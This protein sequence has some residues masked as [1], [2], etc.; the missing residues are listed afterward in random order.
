MVDDTIYLM[1]DQ[2]IVL[3]V[4]GVLGAGL[5][6]GGIGLIFQGQFQAGAVSIIVGGLIGLWLYRRISNN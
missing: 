5:F 1:D 6:V 4:A 3:L 2:L